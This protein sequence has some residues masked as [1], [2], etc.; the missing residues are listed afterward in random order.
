MHGIINTKEN[1]SLHKL[2]SDYQDVFFLPGGQIKLHKRGQAC[3]TF[4]AGGY[5]PKYT[6]L[7]TTRKQEEEIDRQVKQLL[8]DGIIVKSHSPW[9][10]SFH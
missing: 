9:N 1:K 4:G 6:T 7:P 3:Y 5:P 10:S 2:C 8:E